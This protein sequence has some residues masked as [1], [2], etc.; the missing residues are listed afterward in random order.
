MIMILI[1]DL[2]RSHIEVRCE[3]SCQN[4]SSYCQQETF[5]W[6]LLT[7][8]YGA[9]SDLRS[10]LTVKT[11]FSSVWLRTLQ[12]IIALLVPVT[13]QLMYVGLQRVGVLAV[14]QVN[15][16]LLLSD[17][18]HMI[19][20]NYASHQSFKSWLSCWHIISWLSHVSYFLL[21]SLKAE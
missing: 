20:W 15:F 4:I 17:Q 21:S 18:T 19:V 3:C 7:A 12:G 8:L 11:N 9:V 10:S 5:L 1:P 13:I 14:W 16:P 6:C 2:I